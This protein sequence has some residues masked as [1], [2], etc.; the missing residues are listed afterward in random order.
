MLLHLLK[1]ELVSRLPA[2]QIPAVCCSAFYPLQAWEETGS[3]NN[4][5]P[6]GSLWLPII[7]SLLWSQRG[8]STI[9]ED[10][11]SSV[12]ACDLE[13]REKRVNK[14]WY[15]CM[16]CALLIMFHVIS[17]YTLKTTLST[18]MVAMLKDTKRDQFF[19][20]KWDA[21]L[22]N[23]SPL[24]TGQT[25]AVFFFSDPLLWAQHGNK[26]GGKMV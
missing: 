15:A 17:V 2:E 7:H 5:F 14:K 10:H 1:T 25:C 26:Q 11:K 6:R 13:E 12:C 18:C 8:R 21:K 4:V 19:L 9:R 16:T 20:L 23:F 3:M 24:C 22:F